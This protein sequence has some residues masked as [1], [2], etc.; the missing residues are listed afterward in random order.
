[1]RQKLVYNLKNSLLKAN[2]LYKKY[3]DFEDLYDEVNKA[4]GRTSGIGRTMLYDITR[5]IGYFHSIYPDKYVYL[6]AGAKKG[7]KKVLRKQRLPYKLDTRVFA[8]DFPK[9]DSM[10]I[11]DILCIFKDKF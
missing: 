5:M 1:M 9:E 8:N 6:H 4:I 10:Y 3:S 2:I 11:E 7:A